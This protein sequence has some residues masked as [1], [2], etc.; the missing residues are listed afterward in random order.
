MIWYILTKRACCLT[1]SNRICCLSK[2]SAHMLEHIY[3]LI[4]HSLWKCRYLLIEH[5]SDIPIVTVVVS[6]NFT[7]VVS[8]NILFTSSVKFLLHFIFVRLIKESSGTPNSNE[9]SIPIDLTRMQNCVSEQE[10]VDSGH[11]LNVNKNKQTQ[12]RAGRKR[13]WIPFSINFNK[14]KYYKNDLKLIL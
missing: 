14:F 13:N 4:R 1:W 3:N 9:N 12:S 6:I 7:V 10:Q 5:Q 8:I 2:S 11:V